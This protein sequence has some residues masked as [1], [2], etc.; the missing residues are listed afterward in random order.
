MPVNAKQLSPSRRERNDLENLFCHN[1]DIENGDD[2]NKCCES[3]K[4]K[5]FPSYGLLASPDYA[6]LN[7]YIQREQDKE[8]LFI[9]KLFF[10]QK[11]IDR[12]IF[13]L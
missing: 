4:N 11:L 3:Q 5:K 2:Q 9:L 10:T 13:Y 7:D 12:I 6:F 1:C 8:Q